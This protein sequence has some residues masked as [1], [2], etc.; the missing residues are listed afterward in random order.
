MP[1]ITT[2]MLPTKISPCGISTSLWIP[3]RVICRERPVQ[4]TVRLVLQAA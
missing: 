1:T 4:I 2:K 3:A